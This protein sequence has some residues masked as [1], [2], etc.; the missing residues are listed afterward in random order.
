MEYDDETQEDG[1][2]LF[3][4]ADPDM[5]PGIFSKKDMLSNMRDS[6][7]E[8][9]RREFRQRQSRQ[10]RAIMVAVL[11]IVLLAL[12]QKRSDLFGEIPA[13]MVSGLQVVVIGV[14]I[15]FTAFNWRC[16]ACKK[17]LG[18]DI[19]RALC[20]KCGARLR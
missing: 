3:V 10:L 12:V 8:Q 17:Y 14:F 5:L 2:F 7:T 1:A 13:K 15:G 20:N 9:I 16:P 18:P 4:A 19:R 6:N 11:I